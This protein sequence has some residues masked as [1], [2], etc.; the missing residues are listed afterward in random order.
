MAVRK[1]VQWVAQQIAAAESNGMSKA[2][3]YRQRGGARQG[4]CRRESC[5]QSLQAGF[6]TSVELAAVSRSGRAWRCLGNQRAV[7]DVALRDRRLEPLRRHF[8]REIN[9]GCE[10]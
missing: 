7:A 10:M 6:G 4:S 8:K 9:K 3:F 1:R 2:A 5:G